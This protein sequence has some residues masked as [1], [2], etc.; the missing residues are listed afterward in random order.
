MALEAALATLA[1]G[2]RI[3]TAGSAGR[4]AVAKLKPP[5][6][7]RKLEVI[8][9]LTST[10]LQNAPIDVLWRTK[11]VRFADADIAN[12]ATLGGMPITDF[13]NPATGTL[14]QAAV[15]VT[16]GAPSPPGV[17]GVLGA[18]SGTI[19]IP[20]DV[21]APTTFPVQADVRWRV[22]GQQGKSV[23]D[24]LWRIAGGASGSGGEIAP[25]IAQALS[26]LTLDFV[27]FTDHLGVDLPTVRRT[28]QAALRLEAN[29][30]STGW[31]D[32]PAVDLDVVAIPVPTVAMLC[33]GGQL[34]SNRLV[35]V[36]GSS[37]FITQQALET[38]LDA[39][40]VKL[41]EVSGL[42]SFLGHLVSAITRIKA[43]PTNV[44]VG[45]K[46][47]DQI[48]NL[49]DIDFASGTLNDDEVEDEVSSMLLLGPPGRRIECFNAR[50]LSTSEGMMVVDVGIEM[51]TVVE[52]LHSAFPPS[53]LAGHVAVPKP[54]TGTRFF[55]HDITT[56]GNE[57]SS[58]RFSWK[59]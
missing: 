6:E 45:F 38:V 42:V 13:L 16:Q 46:N 9:L 59:T 32:L 54:P 11:D 51:F 17:P 20:I 41:A 10:Q 37:P 36:P 21:T 8:D 12:L 18:L 31:I 4:R 50:N 28:L 56:F 14:L 15:Q 3:D 26:E 5:G 49:N 55:L 35:I 40:N 33:Q 48:G 52:N 29:G 43:L 57:F 23:S 34:G 25:P 22:R 2:F 27:I 24:F 53:D 47:A 44:R 7:A 1:Q 58:V 39:L 19:P 30:V